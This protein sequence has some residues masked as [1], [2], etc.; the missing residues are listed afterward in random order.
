MDKN[1]VLNGLDKGRIIGTDKLTDAERLPWVEHPEFKGV[2]LKNLVTSADTAGAFSCH[3]VRISPG[4]AVA[5]HSH[6]RLWELNEVLDGSGTITLAGKTYACTPGDT[7]V[8]PPAV[9]HSVSASGG[10][11]Y[12]TAKF[13]PALL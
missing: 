12:I 8:N 5:E 1:S 9:P 7:C 4:C 2:Y 6:A 10:E 11:L 13:I 3:L